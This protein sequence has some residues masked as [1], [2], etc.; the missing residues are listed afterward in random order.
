MNNGVMGENSS[1]ER[2]E[3]LDSW[4]GIC[5]CLVALFHFHTNSF[6][7]NLSFFKNAYLFVDFFF[8]LSGFIIFSTYE[9]RL[10]A[11]LSLLKFMVLRFGRLYP[12]H[13]AVL[14]AFIGWDLIQLLIPQIGE[15]AKYPPFSGPGENIEYIL[16]NLTLTH[17]LGIFNYL[18]LNGP[19]WS[20]STEFY[21]YLVF[22]L[23]ILIF[24]DKI[25][26]FLALI[27]VGGFVFLFFYSPKY[28]DTTYSYGFIRCIYGFS[29]G[30]ITYKLR[31]GLPDSWYLFSHRAT[32][33]YIEICM[34][35]LVIFYISQAG[36]GPLSVFAPL[37]FSV[38]VVIFSHQS[39]FVSNILKM[40]FFLFIG[41]ISYSIYMNQVLIGGKLFS[42]LAPIVQTQFGITLFSSVDGVK[43]L[44][45]TPLQ[46]EAI[47][48][49]FLLVL[50]I[51]S[52]LSFYIVE[53]PG[54]EFFRRLVRRVG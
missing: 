23:A 20:I 48:F 4:R 25:F 41:L 26:L 44:G 18:A 47:N 21:A 45:A 54:R 30:A 14:L 28:M 12:L 5:A 37:V 15:Y 38:A 6:T 24:R 10:K 3:V 36:V 39:G 49:A 35:M 52:W 31:K 33:S 22:A 11:G 53:H 27:A 16:S 9:E 13:F 1:V 19:S 29:L 43:R 32:A 40:R 51:V 34:V 50:I 17:S 8:V 42:G 2:F 7:E 46:G